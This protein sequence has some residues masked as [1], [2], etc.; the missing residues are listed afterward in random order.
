MSEGLS[1]LLVT[2]VLTVLLGVQAQRAAA[3]SRLRQAFT[4]G[5]A[6][7]LVL[8]FSNLLVLLNLGGEWLVSLHTLT[9]A[10]F[11][12]SIL[13][14]VIALFN[15]EFQA[16]LRQAREL[17]AAERARQTPSRDAKPTAAAEDHD[18]HRP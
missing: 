15:G 4:I 5:A 13:M 9:T 7:M 14:A 16:K 6:S 10:L 2:L 1:T 18:E 12:V 17:V 8:T 3:G 11:L